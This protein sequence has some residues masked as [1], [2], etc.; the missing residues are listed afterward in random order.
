M[1][2]GNQRPEEYLKQTK[3][4]KLLLCCGHLKDQSVYYPPTAVDDGK[5]LRGHPMHEHVGWYTVD[6]DKGRCPDY[7]A[8]LE[9]DAVLT[10]LTHVFHKCLK[11]IYVEG[12]SFQ[13]VAFHRM[14]Y[15]TLRPGGV[16]LYSLEQNKTP[17][18]ISQL[19]E[20]LS[21]VGFDLANISF[22]HNPFAEISHRSLRKAIMCYPNIKMIEEIDNRD[23]LRKL[24]ETDEQINTFA[25]KVHFLTGEI[26]K[27]L[28][29]LK[30]LSQIDPF[31]GWGLSYEYC[32]HDYVVT[33][34]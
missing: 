23:L 20:T 10:Y 30:K 24:I 1:F 5:D 4:P 3:E 32:R 13:S 34:L 22:F 14:A 11:V 2:H 8:D 19:K 7:V 31:L 29:Y 25:Y 27:F 15:Q 12:W 28:N 9:D 21:S 6:K 17:W 33:F 26:P 18:H 16:L